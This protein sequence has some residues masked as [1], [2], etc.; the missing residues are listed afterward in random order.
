MMKWIYTIIIKKK[1]TSIDSAKFI[2]SVKYQ[3]RR[4]IIASLTNYSYK[5]CS[6]KKY[7]SIEW[8]NIDFIV[9]NF[10]FHYTLICVLFLK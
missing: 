2:Y 9:F 8:G 1:N 3:T 10:I 7:G 5:K 6:Y 4:G